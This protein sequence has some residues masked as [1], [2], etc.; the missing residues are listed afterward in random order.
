MCQHVEFYLFPHEK[1]FNISTRKHD[2]RDLPP[3][4]IEW[5]TSSQPVTYTAIRYKAPKIAPCPKINIYFDTDEIR[6]QMI[7]YDV[8]NVIK[9]KS[10]WQFRGRG[11]L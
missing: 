6:A 3:L 5:H 9:E 2:Q 10:H 7:P 11:K 4:Y 8:F 1:H